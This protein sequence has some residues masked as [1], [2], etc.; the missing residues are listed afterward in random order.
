MARVAQ[1]QLTCVLV[2]S[3][4]GHKRHFPYYSAVPEIELKSRGVGGVNPGRE[5]ADVR[6][7]VPGN[8]Q[9]ASTSGIEVCRHPL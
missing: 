4:S 8:F 5:P 2:F 6:T 9:A 3:M 1:P 7:F